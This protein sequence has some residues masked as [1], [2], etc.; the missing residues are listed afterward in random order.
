M[1]ILVI[2]DEKRLSDVLRKGLTEEG[3]TVDVADDGEA[4][5]RMVADADYDL[6][7]LD[8][9]LPKRSGIDLLRQL[10]GERCVAPVLML[11][12]RI[13]IADRVE[14]LDA[15]A[16]DYL[17]KPFAF[18]ELLARVRALLRRDHRD[19]RAMLEIDDLVVDP[20]TH[21]VKRGGVTV[22]LSSREYALLEYF[23]RNQNRVLSRTVIAEH[24]WDFPYATTTNV[25]DV[26]VKYLR[27][28]LDVGSRRPLIHT[29]RGAG[30]IMRLEE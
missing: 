11:T 13:E 19:A 17:T 6:I 18:E 20:A 1:R 16:D 28:K 7:I 9:R 15:G 10:R 12:A 8:W 30:Y 27:D 2:E 5:Y 23:L 25:I 3:Y 26:Y 4:G 21:G 14:G 22:P 29:V 24:V